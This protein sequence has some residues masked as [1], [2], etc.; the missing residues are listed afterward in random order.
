MLVV[1]ISHILANPMT[2]KFGQVLTPEDIETIF[3]PSP[4]VEPTAVQPVPTAEEM[5]VWLP[6]ADPAKRHFRWEQNVITGE[7]K[8]IELTLDEYKARH[9]GKIISRNEY[10]VR[11]AAEIRKTRREALLEAFLDTLDK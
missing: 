10:V 11:K 3:T 4:W 6:D 7:R 9:I 5:A 1:L 8:A 2:H